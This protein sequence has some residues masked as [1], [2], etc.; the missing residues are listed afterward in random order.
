MNW[1]KLHE[2]YI[3]AYCISVYSFH[4]F[5]LIYVEQMV[6]FVISQYMRVVF[7]QK[8]NVQTQRKEKK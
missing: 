7:G 5:Y 3:H 1:N 6:N 4:N 2:L 8:K